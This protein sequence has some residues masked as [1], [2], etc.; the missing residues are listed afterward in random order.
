MV[1]HTAAVKHQR[2]SPALT[3]L[4]ELTEPAAPGSV[5]HSDK[6]IQ[7][8][9]DALKDFKVM[10]N[11]NDKAEMEDNQAHNMAKGARN[12]QIKAMK[13]SVVDMEAE[14]AAKEER[15]Q[16]A[17]EDK[18]QTTSDRDADQ[19]FLDE[20]TTQC[21]A[22][23]QA[24]DARSSTRTAELVAVSKAIS[25]LKEEVVGNYGAN[26]KLVALNEEDDQ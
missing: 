2:E 16:I 26:K 5:F 14:V 12:Q 4:L 1:A 13:Q 19:N 3:A 10:K 21:E 6:I 7:V 11:D 17:E 8:I 24:W 18:T 20:L 9:T 25:V 15:K 23:A 22:K